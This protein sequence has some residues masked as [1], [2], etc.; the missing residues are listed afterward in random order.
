M[1]AINIANDKKRD[2]TVG[3][4][5]RAKKPLIQMVLMDGSERRNVKFL[6]TTVSAASL[7]AQFGDLAAAGKAIIEGDPEIDRELAGKIIGKTRKVY[8]DKNNA[9]AYHINQTQVLYNADGTEKEKR[10]LSKALA[11]IAVETPLQWSG[12]QFPKMEAARKFVFTKKYQM[13]HTN[14][15]SYDF[16]YG[17][18]KQLH[19]AK[20]LMFIGAGKKGNEPVII[21]AGGEPYRAFLEGRIDGE[22]YCLILHL[23]NIEVKPLPEGEAK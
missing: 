13:R 3:F 1:R 6:K 14:G 17:M 10:E 23:T 20:A 9:I 19:E 7:A 18:A 2:A 16:L 5:A 8:V 15:L 11:N 21:T 22:K 12:R 4:E